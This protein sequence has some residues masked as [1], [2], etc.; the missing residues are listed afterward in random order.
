MSIEQ[1]FRIYELIN[2]HSPA[3]RFESTNEGAIT[4][5][6]LSLKSHDPDK[7]ILRKEYRINPEELKEIQNPVDLLSMTKEKAE[8]KKEFKEEIGKK[9]D[10]N[11]PMAGA[12]I[13]VF[14]R[15]VM[16]IGAVIKKGS[17]K[18]PNPN[19]WKLNEDIINRYFDSEIRHMC[20]HFAG[21]EA[22]E[23][24]TL[25]HLVHAAWNAIAI[26]EKYL[27]EHPEIDKKIMFPEEKRD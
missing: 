1:I 6:F 23:E 9:F 18:Y 13:R 3:I 15:A 12:I 7:F 19:N 26:L 27:M 8:Y 14:P 24:T 17:E 11:K 2:G 10:S 20:K 21:Y 25:P 5:T 4:Q 22:D 16:A